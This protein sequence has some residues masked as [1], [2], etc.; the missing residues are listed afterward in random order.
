MREIFN[1][2]NIH[3]ENDVMLILVDN[4]LVKINLEVLFTHRHCL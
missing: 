1:I 4:Q 3:F 2:E